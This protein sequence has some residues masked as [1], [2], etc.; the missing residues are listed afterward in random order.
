MATLINQ[1]YFINT[2]GTDIVCAY[3]DIGADTSGAGRYTSA[4]YQ[5]CSDDDWIRCISALRKAACLFKLPKDASASVDIVFD[6][7]NANVRPTFFVEIHRSFHLQTAE[8]TELPKEPLGA[9][10][11][12]ALD[13]VKKSLDAALSVLPNQ[14]FRQDGPVPVGSCADAG[15]DGGV[16]T[17]C[18]AGTIPECDDGHLKCVPLG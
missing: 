1:N 18:P 14:P 3:F 15:C 4:I 16:P 9:E 13:A 5:I 7:R 6:N 10:A 17:D 8:C 2:Y 12:A 11:K